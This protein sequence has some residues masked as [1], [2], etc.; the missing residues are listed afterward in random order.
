MACVFRVAVY[1]NTWLRSQSHQVQEIWPVPR[2]KDGYLNSLLQKTKAKRADTTS[3][4]R[5][6]PPEGRNH[7]FHDVYTLTFNCY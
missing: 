2:G 3:S 7:C 4:L 1:G 6:Q 5:W